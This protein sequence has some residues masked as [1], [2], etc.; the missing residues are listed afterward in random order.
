MLGAH[1]GRRGAF[2]LPSWK[3][4]AAVVL[5]VIVGLV[6]T[7]VT[8]GLFMS[9][10]V[11]VVNG[12]ETVMNCGVPGNN[13][14]RQA[15]CVAIFP[16]VNIPQQEVYWFTTLDSS[17]H[18]LNGQ[19][20]YVLYFPPGELPPNNASWSLT[21]TT[22]TNK[23]VNNSIG[24]Y[25][26]GEFS[27]L[28]PNANGSVTIYI[29]NAEPTGNGSNWLPA[30]TGNFKLWL[31]VFLPGNAVLNGSYVVPPVVEVNRT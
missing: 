12:W 14:I 2:S 26:V 17:H 25:S 19:N 9:S 21:M 23:F 5:G 18:A 24:R 28:V 4:V 13:F 1:A 30:P 11:S 7:V 3:T 27:G 8:A 6:L 20:D 15:A 31:R 10:Q 16:M 29:Q 22:T